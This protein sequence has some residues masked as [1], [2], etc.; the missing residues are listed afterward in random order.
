M[1][2]GPLIRDLLDSLDRA[3]PEAGAARDRARDETLA[4]LVAIFGPAEGEPDPALQARITRAADAVVA[5]RRALPP[6]RP[7][8]LASVGDA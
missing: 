5:E 7:V 4:L 2:T 3:L 1:V 6:F 8:A